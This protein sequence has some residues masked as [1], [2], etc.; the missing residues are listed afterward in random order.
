MNLQELFRGIG[1]V[2]DDN[3]NAP[4]D[5]DDR[6]VKIVKYLEEECH[7]PLVKYEYVPDVNILNHCHS[8]SFILLD[9]SLL[10]ELPSG[11]SGSEAE[12]SSHEDIISFLNAAK[13]KCFAP[14]FLFSNEDIA[15]IQTEIRKAV[16][17]N[18]PILFKSKSELIDPNDKVIFW[19]A[20][21]EWFNSKS[22]IYVQKTWNQS[23]EKARVDFMISLNKTSA[24]WPKVIS[25][26]AEH[27][28][29]SPSDEINNLIVQNLLSRME[30]VKFDLNQIELDSKP[31]TSQDLISILEFQRFCPVSSLSEHHST[32][33][34]YKKD[35]KL[36][37]NIRPA[38]DCVPRDGYDEN[39]YLLEC[40]T[41]GKQ[42]NFNRKYGNHSEKDNEV[43]IG[44]I[45]K[46]HYYSVKLKKFFIGKLSEY[47]EYRI[48][49]IQHPFITKIIQKYGL[50]LQRQGLP[51]IPL[52]AIY[53]PKEIEGMQKESSDF[54][55]G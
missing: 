36:Y 50:Y 13:D 31:A 20:L 51:R 40:N 21:E 33:D 25:K 43:I 42:E 41:H 47:K 28:S 4:I 37:I 24:H 38:C 11:G 27:D 19:S 54:G 32:G 46:N 18:L 45:L 48:G 17:G 10:G 39:L 26:T 12:K 44:P 55:E 30:P 15:N 29:V 49:R 8:I 53:S 14:I 52:E 7:I 9:W 6:I 16:G 5:S 1:I 22:G 35:D 34:V 23:F 3:V 2:I